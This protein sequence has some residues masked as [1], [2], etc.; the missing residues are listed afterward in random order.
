MYTIEFRNENGELV[1]LEGETLEELS[2]GLS[3]WHYDGPAIRVCR[4][5]GET[6]GWVKSDYWRYA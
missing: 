4:E 3:G 2:H 1:E 6:V 5:N